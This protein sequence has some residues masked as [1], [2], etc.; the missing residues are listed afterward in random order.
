MVG[1]SI[2]DDHAT[3]KY[4]KRMCNFASRD[5]EDKVLKCLLKTHLTNDGYGHPILSPCDKM[6]CILLKMRIK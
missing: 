4:V 3:E 2:M 5:E 6:N 1:D